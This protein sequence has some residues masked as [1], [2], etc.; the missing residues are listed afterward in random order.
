MLAIV[1]W[2]GEPLSIRKKGTLLGVRVLAPLV[3]SAVGHPGAGAAIGGLGGT[4]A[5][6][7]IG[8]IS[9]T[10]RISVLIEMATIDPRL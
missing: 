5:G 3:G 1:G 4:A 10:K 2:Y 8:P 6:Y 7:W 9:R